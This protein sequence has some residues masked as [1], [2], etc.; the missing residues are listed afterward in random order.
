MLVYLSQSQLAYS[1]FPQDWKHKIISSLVHSSALWLRQKK[2]LCQ[3]KEKVLCQ[4][5]CQI[6]IHR[7][8]K[9]PSFRHPVSYIFIHVS[10]LHFLKKYNNRC[11]LGARMFSE[12][13][14]IGAVL[15]LVSNICLGKA[16]QNAGQWLAEK[17]YNDFQIGFSCFTTFPPSWECRDIQLAGWCG[18]R[19]HG[20]GT[21]VVFNFSL[22]KLT[23]KPST[24]GYHYT[25]QNSLPSH[26]T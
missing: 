17:F 5:V 10:P 1:N 13:G 7:S 25:P 19:V 24:V 14:H 8:R 26:P 23:S 3:K 9:T 6:V 15:T 16:Y 22:F 4:N 2:V 11:T 18:D 12:T 21:N 20:I